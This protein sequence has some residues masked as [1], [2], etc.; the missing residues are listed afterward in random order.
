M[1][2]LGAMVTVGAAAVEAVVPP[3]FKLGEQQYVPDGLLPLPLG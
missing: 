1:A 3:G 2:A